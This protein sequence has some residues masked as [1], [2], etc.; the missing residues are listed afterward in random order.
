MGEMVIV[1]IIIGL[2]FLALILEIARPAFIVF[3]TLM[4]LLLTGTITTSEALR[5]F[6]NE[7]MLTIAL[8]FIIAGAIGKNPLL[9][10]FIYRMIG[11]SSS[12]RKTL[13]RIMAPISGLSAFFNNTPII[14]MIIPIIRKWCRQH[15]MPISKFLLPLSYA[16]IFGGMIT[17]IGTATNL[18]VHGLML[19]NGMRG[20]FMFQLAIVGIP[21]AI[22]GT[23]YVI[24]IGS[25]LLPKDRKTLEES[26]VEENK[27][28][29]T[30]AIINPSCEIVGQTVKDA[31][32]KGLFL[33]E[34]IR[35]KE[36]IT[37]V[38]PNEVIHA[39]DHLI[40]S[41]TITTIMELQM[42][43]G[44]VIATNATFTFQHLHQKNLRLVE[45]MISSNSPLLHKTIK[46]RD[47]RKSIMQRWLPSENIS[48][49]QMKRL[50]I[51]N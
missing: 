1:V 15:N 6:S 43:R 42:I 2:M 29:L 51:L 39:E 13:L 32:L 20:L 30:K 17:L 26:F 40:F 50:G 47:I 38:L 49:N 11:N 28:Y 5:G 18:V 27:N 24:F 37:P 35:G 34:I 45:A 7:G 9:Y 16:S 33:I 14:V 4:F 8:L 41:G 10:S 23:I 21:G 12:Y 19:E 22:I 44:L 36:R 48:K 31:D 46:E 25:K 3:T